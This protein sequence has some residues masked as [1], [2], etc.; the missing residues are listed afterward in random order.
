MTGPSK[1]LSW[2][3]LTCKDGTPYP[4]KWRKNRLLPLVA[5][6]EFLRNYYGLSIIVL[7]AYRTEKYNNKIGGARNSQHKEGRALDLRPP[8]GVSVD[9][10]YI[11]IRKWAEH[12]GIGGVGK[13]ETFVHIDTRPGTAMVVWSGNGKKDS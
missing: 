10:F 6:F 5:A 3:E 12:M 7:S 11:F 13:Y 9:E 8:V 4:E 1:H 2:E